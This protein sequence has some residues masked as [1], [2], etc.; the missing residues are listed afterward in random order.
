M[1]ELKCKNHPDLRW[2]TKDVAVN[3]DGSYNGARRLF[4]KGNGVDRVR[5]CFDTLRYLDEC[6]CPASDLI[7]VEEA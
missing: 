1:V 5:V 2:N 7:R 4:F 3:K 6:S